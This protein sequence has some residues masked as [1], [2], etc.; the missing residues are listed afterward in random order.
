[1]DLMTQTEE[2]KKIPGR[3]TFQNR[4]EGYFVAGR[5]S[6]CGIKAGEQVMIVSYALLGG[7]EDLSNV[8]LRNHSGSKL[9][10]L[11][12]TDASWRFVMA[13]A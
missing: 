3:W 2:P 8:V 11:P 6:E 7:D 9:F 5:N 1:M 4:P 10:D 12:D 13:D